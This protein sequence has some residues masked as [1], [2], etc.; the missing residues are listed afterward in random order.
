MKNVTIMFLACLFSGCQRDIKI[1][2]TFNPGHTIIKVTHLDCEMG[3]DKKVV[4]DC[5][6]VLEDDKSMRIQRLEV[7]R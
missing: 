1:N 5:L 3:V 6:Y 4:F 2:P 7:R